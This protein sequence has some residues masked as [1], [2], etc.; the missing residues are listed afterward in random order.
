MAANS[1]IL[2]VIK[3]VRL[4]TYCSLQRNA[5]HVRYNEGSPVG[6]EVIA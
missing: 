2:T 3:L 6:L 5:V 1:I 4:G